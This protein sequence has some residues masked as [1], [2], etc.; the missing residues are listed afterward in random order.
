MKAHW[1]ACMVISFMIC[2]SMH[3]IEFFYPMKPT[4]SNVQRSE[5]YAKRRKFIHLD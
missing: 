1:M 4:D 2:I 3:E 5:L